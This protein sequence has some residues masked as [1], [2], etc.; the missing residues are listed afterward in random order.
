MKI[1]FTS[2]GVGWD[3]QMDP[4]FGRAEFILVF[5]EDKNELTH[6]DN[7][8]I[9]QEAHGAGPQT[10]KV[11]FDMGAN[12]LITGNGP[13]GNAGTILEKTG[14]KSYIGAGEMTIKEAYES[15]KKGELEKL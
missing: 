7:S 10:A 4:R 1:A 12:I 11:L 13:G 8:A 6:M 9:A 3:S 5:D 15:Y 2:K 14:I